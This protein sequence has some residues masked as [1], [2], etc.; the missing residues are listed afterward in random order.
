MNKNQEG[1]IYR[2]IYDRLRSAI[3]T[4]QM[5]SGEQLPSTRTLAA[6]IGVSRNSVLA[7]VDQL[8]SEGFLESRH[9]AGTFVSQSLAQ[10]PRHHAQHTGK[11]SARGKLIAATAVSRK[12][13]A[14]GFVPF[15]PGLPD[16]KS[17]PLAQFSRILARQIRILPEEAFSYGPAA[18]WQPLQEAIALYLR[19]ARGVVCNPNQVLVV[20]G[21]QACLDLCARVL[22]DPGDTVGIE[23]PGYL[24]ARGAFTSA[25]LR[26]A[27]FGVDEEGLVVSQLKKIKG[28]R[29]VYVTPSHQFPLGVTMSLARRLE[30]TQLAQKNNFWI[31]EDDYD[32]EYRFHGKPLSALQGLDPSGRVI[33]TG[34]FSKVLFP[35]LRIGYIVVPEN[36]IQAFTQCHALAAGHAPILEQ[37]AL[38][39]FM[40]SGAFYRHLRRMRILYK[41][42][43]DTLVQEAKRLRGLL[44]VLPCEAGMQLVG[45]LRKP[46]KDGGRSLA[47]LAASMGLDLA[48]IADYATGPM[49]RTGFL[50]GYSGFSA[51]EIK[52]GVAI[53]DRILKR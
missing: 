15:T 34:T 28:L 8:T 30:L 38:A 12:R 40:R 2:E 46:L 1:F 19:M 4:G 33:Y 36:T 37:A 53:L 14:T 51:T 16:L 39:E 27:S 26:I 6:Q 47:K 17:L 50:L 43:Q 11:L 48:P 29:G 3:L 49:N 24:G 21:S 10:L 13:L 44:D 5:K 7:A 23:N 45:W 18:G 25:A 42:R 41:E 32:S 9:G 20:S 52:R 35:G 31:I 22:F